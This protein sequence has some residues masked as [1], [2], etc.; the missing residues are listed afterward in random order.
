[1]PARRVVVLVDDRLSVGERDAEKGSTSPRRSN[2]SL[3]TSPEANPSLADAG[4][5]IWPP[6]TRQTPEGLAARE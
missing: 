1:M 5:R 6:A 3:A 2:T 4:E